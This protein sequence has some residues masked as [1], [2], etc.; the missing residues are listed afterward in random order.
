[1]AAARGDR[2]V[3]A[4]LVDVPWLRPRLHDPATVV[5]DAT[6]AKSD[7]GRYLSG[8]NDFRELGHIPGARHAD[9]I[10]EFSSPDASFPFTRPTAAAFESAARRLGIGA[11]STVVVYD[12]RS[13][14][15][16]ARLWWLLRSFGHRRVR[17]L[18]GG[19]AAWVRGGGRLETGA[20]SAPP[21]GDF[22][23]DP[24]PGFFVDIDEVRAVSDG[25]SAGR[26]VCA[27][28]RD[29]FDGH[30]PIAGRLGH[31]PG[32]ASVPYTDLLDEHDRL[33]TAATRE[34]AGRLTRR[35]GSARIVGYCGGGVNA[36]GL[37]LA[38]SV[39][40]VTDVAVY[41]GS[42]SEWNADP[43]NPLRV[44]GE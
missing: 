28:P 34:V 5:L 16:A 19:L 23:A 18:D 29:V 10:A 1:M 27:L 33:D 25:R 35:T 12:T 41:D 22:S 21:P 40:G 15:W 14:A 7:D 39:A 43:T 37:A 17:V 36:A 42:L 9:L 31:I 26:L 4:T 6:V 30:T 8:H 20:S 32:S 11:D 3:T 2:P 13:G 38:L 44:G 24:Q